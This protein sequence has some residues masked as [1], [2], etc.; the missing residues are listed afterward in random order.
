MINNRVANTGAVSSALIFDPT[1][2]VKAD[3]FDEFGGYFTWVGNSQS[4][5]N[6]MLLLNDI[7]NKSRVYRAIASAN[8]DYKMHFLPDL[9]ANLN[10]AYD[11]SQGRGNTFIP[12]YMP[13]QVLNREGGQNTD[14]GSS[15]QNKLLEFYLNYNKEV[16]SVKS[17]FDIMAGYSYQDWKTHITNYPERLPNMNTCPN[18][19]PAALFCRIPNAV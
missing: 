7:T 1:Q 9:R 11:F 8:I 18:L 19:Y 3:G 14:Y 16:S 15:N 13:V 6:P 4:V 10:I 2:P 12:A 5:V 17:T